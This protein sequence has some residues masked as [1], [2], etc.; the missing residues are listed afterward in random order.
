VDASGR[1][2]LLATKFRAKRKDPNF[3]QFC[4]YSWFRNVRRP[5]NH[6]SGW[7]LFYFIGMNQA[8]GWQFPLRD[9]KESIG[10]VV[11]K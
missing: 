8:W 2:C 11:D 9:G 6:L 4:I 7:G 10:I 5:G 3:N 1:R